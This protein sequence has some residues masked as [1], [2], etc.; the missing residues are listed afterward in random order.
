MKYTDDDLLALIE[1]EENQSYQP[2]SGTLKDEREKALEYYLGEEY[3]NEIQDRSQVITRETLEVVESTLPYLLK[4]FTSGD[5]VVKFD[6]VGPEDIDQAEQET[7]YVN[8]VVTQ[9]NNWFSI[10]HTWFKDALLEK[11]GYVKIFW[12]EK[13]EYT[14]ERYQGL[15]EDELAFILSD[16]DV[17]I[18]EQDVAMG[19]DGMPVYSVKLKQLTPCKQVRIQNLPPEEVYV[20]MRARAVQLQ[21]APFVQ[22]RSYKTMSELRA[23]G[24]EKWIHIPSEDKEIDIEE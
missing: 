16:R 21:D 15:S 2:D 22:H 12:E 18:I 23:A 4:T 9:K 11:V 10:A 17:E 13:E 19:M 7:E 1:R 3:G 6:P 5:Q 24:Y 20:S 8:F 14:E